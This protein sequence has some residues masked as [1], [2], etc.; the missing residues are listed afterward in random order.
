M[1]FR[2]QAIELGIEPEAI[3]GTLFWQTKSIAIA[4]LA[5]SASSSG[6]SPFVFSKSKKYANNYSKSE[7][8][9]L[10]SK[11]ITMYHDAHRGM[12]DLELS[13]ESFL[14]NLAR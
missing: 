12:N 1:L 11:L 2:S 6:L 4:N 8:S 9:E 5:S 14:L 3:A 7:I 13:I 10:N